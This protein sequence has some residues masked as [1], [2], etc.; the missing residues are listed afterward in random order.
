MPSQS[1]HVNHPSN[2]T[3]YNFHGPTSC[4]YC[5]MEASLFFLHGFV[6]KSMPRSDLNRVQE[7]IL[8]Q[9]VYMDLMKDGFKAPDEVYSSVPRFRHLL[10]LKRMVRYK[11]SDNSCFDK[12]ADD[13]AQLANQ[14]NVTKIGVCLTKPPETI[15][16]F[17][18][19][20]QVEMPFCIF[21]SHGLYVNDNG[22]CENHGVYFHFCSRQT[23]VQYLKVRLNPFHPSVYGNT[24][25]AMVQHQ[26]F[27]ASFFIMGKVKEFLTPREFEEYATKNLQLT[28]MEMS[29]I[30]YQ[31]NNSMFLDSSDSGG[32]SATSSTDISSSTTSSTSESAPLR[33]DLMDVIRTLVSNQDKLK[34]Q[35]S[36]LRTENKQLRNTNNK[37]QGVVDYHEKAKEQQDSAIQ[38]KDEKIQELSQKL[39]ALQDSVPHLEKLLKNLSM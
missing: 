39:S 31:L 11:V 6:E 26:M 15:A 29:Q 14:L 24:H 27:E 9:G 16:V 22:R 33:K 38:E 30:D 17:Y 34:K 13:M 4:T 8:K 25:D 37:L 2:I 23:L 5:S 28:S 18:D 7:R 1:I 20:E 19:A 10:K 12:L 35:I 36:Q 32:S 3:Q 21:D